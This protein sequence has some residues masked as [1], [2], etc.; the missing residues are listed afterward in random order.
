MFDDSDGSNGLL[1][2][3]IY[4]DIGEF[5]HSIEVLKSFG[6]EFEWIKDI[7]INECKNQNLRVVKIR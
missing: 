1:T 7:L 2:A 3:E 5:D 4:R 6:E